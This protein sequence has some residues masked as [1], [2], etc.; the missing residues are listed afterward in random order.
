MY[1]NGRGV[2]QDYKLA[3]HWY[4]KAAEQG[5]ALGQYNLGIMYDNGRGVPRSDEI[6]TQWFRKAAE[7]GLMH[8]QNDLG[9]RYFIGRGV[10][11]DDKLAAQW[12][13]ASAEQGMELSRNNLRLMQL[14]GRGGVQ[15][16]GT[17]DGAPDMSLET[18]S[19]EF[20]RLVGIPNYQGIGNAPEGSSQWWSDQIENNPITRHWLGIPDED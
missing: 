14:L 2:T 10:P 4:R 13:R 8:A 6:A 18:P 11:Q 19:E 12:F 7:Q 3:V 9:V 17:V 5:L 20:G 1:D 16:L 15:G